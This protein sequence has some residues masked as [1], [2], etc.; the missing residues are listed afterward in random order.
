[1]EEILGYAEV[2]HLAKTASDL[3]R[4][5]KMTSAQLSQEGVT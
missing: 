5:A 4:L 1:M 2:G 3:E